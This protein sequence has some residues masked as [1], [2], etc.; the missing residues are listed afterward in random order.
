[1]YR[2]FVDNYKV[3]V[4]T[5]EK[6]CQANSQFAEISEVSLKGRLHYTDK[7]R[8]DIFASLDILCICFYLFYLFYPFYLQN[9]KVKSAKESKDQN[10]KNSLESKRSR[11]I[12]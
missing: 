9:L 6:C 1:M 8:A 3:A 12:H 7:T 11:F 5:A 10:A 4:E 2:A